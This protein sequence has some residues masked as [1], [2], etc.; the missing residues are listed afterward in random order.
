QW[1]LVEDGRL[2][3]A[4]RDAAD[5]RDARNHPPSEPAAAHA[6]SREEHSRGAPRFPAAGTLFFA[7]DRVDE[8]FHLPADPD[9]KRRRERKISADRPGEGVSPRHLRHESQE[10]TD[11]DGG[12]RQGLREQTPD[13]CRPKRRL[14]G[15]P[16]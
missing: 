16:L 6:P 15:G 11:E 2:P 13:E 12:P 3:T 5:D 10:D 8:S 7:A 1:R 14:R 9:G 4:K